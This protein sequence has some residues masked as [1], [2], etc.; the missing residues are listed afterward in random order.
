MEFV[1]KS[2]PA[3][4]GV[5]HQLD[6]LKA[7]DELLLQD[8]WGAITYKGNGVFIAGGAGVTPFIG[9]FKWL[10]AQG[11]VEGNFLIFSNKTSKVIILEP[12][13]RVLLGDNFISILSEEESSGSENGRID[14]VF[15]KKHI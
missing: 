15:L 2:Y 13:F 7:E 1:I 8:S 14:S 3:H 5:T 12:Y 4:D 9:I 10:E 11:K 6:Q